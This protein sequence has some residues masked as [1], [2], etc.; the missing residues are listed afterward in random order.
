MTTVILIVKTIILI[1]LQLVHR[2][3]SLLED[4]RILVK[5]LI[6][7]RDYEKLVGLPYKKKCFDGSGFDCWSLVHHIY[8]MNNIELPMNL[9]EGWA[10][11]RIHKKF[12][13]PGIVWREV[14]LED[15]RVL[16]ILLFATSYK[17]RTHIGLVLDYKYFIHA[18]QVMNVVIEKFTRSIFASQIY[19]VYRWQQ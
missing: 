2:L 4:F 5:A 18:H 15:R 7:I 10:V 11:R 9:L 19:K 6:D 13:T 16:D 14:E 1:K 8:L 12:N 17:L 3:V